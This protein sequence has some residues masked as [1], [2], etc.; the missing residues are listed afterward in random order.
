MLRVLCLVIGYIFG[1]FQT[2][3]LYGKLHHIDIRSYGSGNSGTTNALRVLGKK[4]G[5]IVFAGDFLKT[6][7]A[8]LLIRILYKGNPSLDLYVLYAG[9]GVVLGHNYPC[10]LHFKGGKGIASMAGILVAMDWRI[11][12]V[13]AVV[14]LAAVIITRYVSLGSILVVITFLIQIII[15]GVRG[16]YQVADQNLIEY[17]CVAGFLTAMAI[18][19]HRANI[20]RLLRGTESKLWG[21]KKN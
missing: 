1:L 17:F 15:Y 19:R 6:V 10:Y 9:V 3:Y 4:A 2:G 16:S 7:F 13:C 18:W 11:T 21:N 12:L 5:L 20:G 14:F 8:C